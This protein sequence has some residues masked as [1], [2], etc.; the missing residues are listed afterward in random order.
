MVYGLWFGKLKVEKLKVENLS[1]L[2]LRESESLFFSLCSLFLFL[3]NVEG[4]Y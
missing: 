1:D 2:C 3:K 4:L